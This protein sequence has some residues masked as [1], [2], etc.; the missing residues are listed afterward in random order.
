MERTDRQKRVFIAIDVLLILMMVLPI[1]TAI[2]LKV[3][4]TPASDGVS[5]TGARIFFT[6][7]MPFQDLPITESQVN[8]ALVLISIF[9]LCLYM[10]HGIKVKAETK[11]QHIAEWIVEKV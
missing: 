9:G 8:S 5:I 3:L 7:P 6:I 4:T 10:T 1:L 2:T 11:R